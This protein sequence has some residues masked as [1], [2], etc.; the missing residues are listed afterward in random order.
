[1]N[2]VKTD[3][4]G[5]DMTSRGRALCDFA[6]KLTRTPQAMSPEDLDGLRDQG[7][8]DADVLDVVQVVSYFNY[9]NRVA[10]ALGVPSEDDWS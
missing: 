2:A 6:I 1:M 9:I 3:Y 10:D 5:A 8:S 4:T 7:L